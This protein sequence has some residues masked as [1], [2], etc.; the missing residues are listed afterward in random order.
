[1]RA[2]KVNESEPPMTHRKFSD[3]VRTVGESVLRE[4]L[5]ERSGD[6]LNG[7]RCKGGKSWVHDFI[8]ERVKS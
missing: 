5:G 7:S 3:A 1:V 8:A 2:E 4:E 6:R